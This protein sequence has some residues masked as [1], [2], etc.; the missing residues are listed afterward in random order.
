MTLLLPDSETTRF[1]TVALTLGGFGFSAYL[2]Y[3]EIFSIHAICEWCATSAVIMTI[4]MA[5]RSGASCAAA[6]LG[7][8]RFADAE[9][10]PEQTPSLSTAP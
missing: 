6:S 10:P 4:L 8:A 7:R 9:R 5:C 1:A 2:T 3:R